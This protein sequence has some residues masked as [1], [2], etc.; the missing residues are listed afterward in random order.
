M[1][2]DLNLHTFSS[3]LDLH[4]ALC[5]T[6]CRA[7]EEGIKSNGAAALALS[8]GS[9]PKA[10][11]AQLSRCELPWDKV[12][13]TLV[14][15]RW[16]EP[17]NSDSNEYLVRTLLLQGLAKEAQFIPLKSTHITAEEAEPAC[18]I[19]LRRLPEDFDVVLLG[20]GTDG[21][22]ASFFPG[23]ATLQEALKS[24]KSCVAVIPPE[25]PYERMTLTFSRLIKSKNI[26]LHIEGEGKMKVLQKARESKD[27]ET[28]PVRA[29][30]HRTST[31]LLE[32]YYAA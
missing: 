4:T 27:V 25:A 24:D 26:F 22:T 11:F 21:H 23:A 15:E 14:D 9:T 18:G 16:T 1:K 19:A 5:A 28:M 7:L 3:R 8:G 13:I 29:F 6:I 30:L 10:L 12:L 2:S 32:V 31:P 17:S 20:M